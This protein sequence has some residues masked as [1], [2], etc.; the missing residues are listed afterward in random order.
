[1]RLRKKH[2]F[3]YKIK[4]QFITMYTYA[5]VAESRLR[6]GFACIRPPGHHAEYNQAMGFCFLNNV[7]ITVKYLQQVFCGI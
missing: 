4:I 6:N 5:Q 2:Y 1:M 3:F 7:A